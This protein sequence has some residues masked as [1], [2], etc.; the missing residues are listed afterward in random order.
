MVRSDYGRKAQKGGPVNEQVKVDTVTVT[1][2]V[3]TVVVNNKWIFV[4]ADETEQETK[5]ESN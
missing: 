4:V 3:R 1:R 2:T 5:H